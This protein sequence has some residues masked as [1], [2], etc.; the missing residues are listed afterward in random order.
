VIAAA[1]KCKDEVVAL[2]PRSQDPVD[3]V[4][5][6]RHGFR[7][8]PR[9]HG[10]RDMLDAGLVEGIPQGAAMRRVNVIV[11]DDGHPRPPPKRGN[12]GSA[13]FQKPAADP[14]VIA[15]LAQLHLHG[16]HQASAFP[17]GCPSVHCAS[18]ERTSSAVCRFDSFEDSTWM[19]ARL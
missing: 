15:S 6:H 18:A 1:S 5:K 11:C 8:F 3:Q 4:G 10:Q 13:L 17:V 9:A 12:H 16:L 14:D 19:S 7:S 2:E